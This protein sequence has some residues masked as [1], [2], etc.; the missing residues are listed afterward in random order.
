MKSI[1][2]LLCVLCFCTHSTLSQNWCPIPGQTAHS[3]IPVCAT[4][5]FTQ[6]APQSCGGVIL[7]ST[8]NYCQTT[9]IYSDENAFWY[10]FTCYQPGTLGF[11]IK[12]HFA[13]DD[14]DWALYDVTGRNPDDVYL[15][16]GLMIACN[17]TNTRG[18]TGTSAAGTDLF[19][20][21]SPNAPAFGKMPTLQP[22]HQYLIV[23]K[24]FGQSIYGYD[25]EFSGGTAVITD[26]VQPTIVNSWYDAT[27]NTVGI[28]INK[29]MLCN[30][31]AMDGSDF[32][33]MPGNIPITLAEGINCHAQVDGDS[34]LLQLSQ[35]LLPGNYSITINTGSDGNTVTDACGRPLPPAAVT[36]FAVPVPCVLPAAFAGNDVT[37]GNANQYSLTGSPYAAGTVLWQQLSGPAGAHMADP[38]AAT[39]HV[40]NLQEGMYTFRYTISDAVCSASDTVMITVKGLPGISCQ[41]VLPNAFSPNNDGKNDLFKP[42]KFCVAG[43]YMFTIFNRWGE[44]IFRSNNP[45]AAWDGYYK[46]FAQPVG[47]YVWMIQ[48]TDATGKAYNYKGTVMLVR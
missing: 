26:N 27:N 10:K 48:Y 23:I 35:P 16:T 28:K 9:G 37:I 40:T 30:T 5:V 41:F 2:I 20:C 34:I 39:N 1:V 46:G 22:L 36:H 45:A 24:D 13:N 12:P 31:I 4:N 3:A 29:F 6:G 42:G 25:L 43:H 15:Q 33:I 18:N 14:Y 11:V 32:T 38:A 17:W 19:T 44:M 8:M 47:V 7:P 21:Y